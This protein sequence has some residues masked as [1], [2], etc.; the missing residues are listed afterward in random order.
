M[1]FAMYLLVDALNRVRIKEGAEHVF[2]VHVLFS[3]LYF[4][5]KVEAGNIILHVT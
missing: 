3:Q 1:H 5:A 2:V 4:I